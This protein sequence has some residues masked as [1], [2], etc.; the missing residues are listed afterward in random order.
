MDEAKEN[1]EHEQIEEEICSS[2]WAAT[3][4]HATQSGIRSDDSE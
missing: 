3:G 4:R 1:Y 2:L